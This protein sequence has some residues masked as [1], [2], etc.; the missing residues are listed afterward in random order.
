MALK[1]LK[2]RLTAMNSNKLPVLA[3]KAGATP[4]IRGRQWMAMRKNTLIAADFACVDCGRVSATNEVD[5]DTP[6]E[7][8]GSND[9]SNRVVRCVEC[10]KAKTK[11]EV[12]SRGRQ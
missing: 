1:T 3:T 2:P 4:R 9:A 10:H 8:G 7:Q 6:L 12:Q 5:H 11:R